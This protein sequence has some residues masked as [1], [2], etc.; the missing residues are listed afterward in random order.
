MI[1]I[2]E[3]EIDNYKCDCNKK[4][5]RTNYNNYICKKC[6]LYI[7]FHIYSISGIGQ[8]RELSNYEINEDGFYDYMIY[9]SGSGIDKI[10]FTYRGND[11]E[12]FKDITTLKDL[13]ILYKQ[14]IEN[15]VFE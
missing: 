2:G 8:F 10:I 12:I 3:K 6:N 13:I 11:I 4:L 7:K 1:I 5:E 9:N 15:L 14:C